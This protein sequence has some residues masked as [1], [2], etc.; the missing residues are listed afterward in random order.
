MISNCGWTFGGDH[1][2]CD[3]VFV[4]IPS[5]GMHFPPV[6]NALN[7]R[8]A[9][10]N[11]YGS[12]CL[13]A[14]ATEKARLSREMSHDSNVPHLRSIS[15]TTLWMAVRQGV[16]SSACASSAVAGGRERVS[17]QSSYSCCRDIDRKLER[18]EVEHHA[19]CTRYS[20][21]GAALV[22]G[23]I[24]AFLALVGSYGLFTQS[25]GM[26]FFSKKPRLNSL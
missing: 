6:V 10:Q 20:C 14:V 9:S 11:E 25:R 7:L 15:D 26:G 4:E 2:T 21:C 22:F 13:G 19:S 23:S 3:T 8:H 12:R 17:L 24:G 5:V 16:L 1:L 18:R